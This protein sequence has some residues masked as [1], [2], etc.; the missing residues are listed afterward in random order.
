MMM[1]MVM[2][3]MHDG[4]QASALAQDIS[5]YQADAVHVIYNKFKVGDDNSLGHHAL[6]SSSS[7]SS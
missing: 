5:K 2:N 1:L 4:W 6:P 7:I 3:W